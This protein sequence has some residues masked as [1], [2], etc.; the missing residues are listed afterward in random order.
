M[1]FNPILRR[2]NPENPEYFPKI[3]TSKGMTLILVTTIGDVTFANDVHGKEE[4]IRKRKS[5]DLLMLAWTG[6][7]ST[8]IFL[9]TDE[10]LEKF[11]ADPPKPKG[12][13]KKPQQ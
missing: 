7:W 2:I 8:D 3:R 12:P 10:D 5:E 13:P 4:I 9:V 6:Q 1:T 11:W